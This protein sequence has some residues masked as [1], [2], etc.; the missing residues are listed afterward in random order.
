MF[1]ECCIRDLGARPEVQCST[2]H[3]IE[4]CQ[5]LL[6]EAWGQSSDSYL[7]VYVG[8][9]VQE[10]YVGLQN[11]HSHLVQLHVERAEAS[12]NICM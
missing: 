8:L 7:G 5:V 4:R 2:K 3:M 11:A 6:T 12:I 9:G 10:A 1:S